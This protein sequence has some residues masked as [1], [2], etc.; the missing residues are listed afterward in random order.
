MGLIL[1]RCVWGGWQAEVIKSGLKGGFQSSTPRLS[2][3]FAV[4]WHLWWPPSWRN[5]I[6]PL[7][8]IHKA[9]RVVECGAGCCCWSC[10]NGIRAEVTHGAQFPLPHLTALWT[11]QHGGNL[12]QIPNFGTTF[13]RREE[14]NPK[15][16]FYSSLPSTYFNHKGSTFCRFSFT[17]RKCKCTVSHQRATMND[18]RINQQLISWNDQLIEQ[19]VRF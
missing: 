5:T 19:S 9:R 17:S 15:C 16:C 11:G 2:V 13:G 10:W 1:Y 3:A 7:S 8:P 12:I 18:L 4:A 6:R 14:H